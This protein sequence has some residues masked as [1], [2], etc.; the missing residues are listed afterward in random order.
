MC[1]SS[2]NNMIGQDT[3]TYQ[4]TFIWNSKLSAYRLCVS[5]FDSMNSCSMIS[6]TSVGEMSPINNCNMKSLT[7]LDE[8]NTSMKNPKHRFSGII[9]APCH[10]L[11]SGWESVVWQWSAYGSKRISFVI[12]FTGWSSRGKAINSGIMCP[13]DDELADYCS[14]YFDGTLKNPTS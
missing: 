13:V 1:T 4:S 2:W 6:I 8:T 11:R 5:F 9:V 10:S 12:P 14:Q 7:V 3:I